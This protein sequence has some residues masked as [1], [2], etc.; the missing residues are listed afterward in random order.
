MTE[1]F[2]PYNYVQKNYYYQKHPLKTAKTG[3]PNTLYGELQK[4]NQNLLFSNELDNNNAILHHL[5]KIEQLDHQTKILIDQFK[6]LESCPLLGSL[7]RRISLQ[8]GT[9]SLLIEKQNLVSN[10]PMN[11]PIQ[12]IFEKHMNGS[13]ESAISTGDKLEKSFKRSDTVHK[14]ALRRFKR[15][16]K[17]LFKTQNISIVKKRYANCKV[18]LLFN[19]MLKTL[20]TIIPEECIT[21]DVI[22]LAMGIIGLKDPSALPCSPTVLQE[23]LDI[24][25]CARRFSKKKYESCL[26]SE[27][28]KV[29]LQKYTEISSNSQQRALLLYEPL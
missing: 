2:T 23:I 10:L 24:V 28:F 7:K 8:T 6:M 25:D 14:S 12:N 16:Y 20:K 17:K 3:L 13:K 18:R 21:D 5:L 1:L 15:F 11:M 26:R 19:K 22:Y 27:S 29:L 4:G 9:E